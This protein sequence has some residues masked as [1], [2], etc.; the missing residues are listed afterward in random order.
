MCFV[1]DCTGKWASIRR[2]HAEADSSG[3]SLFRSALCPGGSCAPLVLLH[4]TPRWIRDLQ[5]DCPQVELPAKSLLRQAGRI[6]HQSAPPGPLQGRR[7]WDEPRGTP[8]AAQ[9]KVRRLIRWP[10]AGSPPGAT[11]ATAPQSA[12]AKQSP[13]PCQVLSK[14]HRSVHSRKEVRGHNAFLGRIIKEV[15]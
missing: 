4:R 8:A 5:A 1:L 2:L 10:Q 9:G 12:R 11:P 7:A 6:N 14:H 13:V 3:P 15:P